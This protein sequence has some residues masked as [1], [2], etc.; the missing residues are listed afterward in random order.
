MS[1]PNGRER[2]AESGADGT[3]RAVEE[4]RPGGIGRL[5]ALFG[6]EPAPAIGRRHGA[7]V[8]YESGGRQ[9]SLELEP[10]RHVIGRAPGCD[11]VLERDPAVGALHAELVHGVDGWS[12]RDLDSKNGTFLDGEPVYH[13][14]L[15]NGDVVQVGRSRLTIG[16]DP[17]VRDPNTLGSAPTTRTQGHPGQI[18]GR[19]DVT[20]LDAHG[21]FPVSVDEQAS[22]DDGS[23][24]IVA[25]PG[26][27]AL[28]S[29]LHAAAESLLLADDHETFA[30][31][32]DVMR[33]HLRAEIA[34]VARLD[35]GTGRYEPVASLPRGVGGDRISQSACRL[36]ETERAAFHIEDASTDDRLQDAESI[37]E[38]S[39]LSVMCAPLYHQGAIHAVVYASTTQRMFDERLFQ[40]FCTLSRYSAVA[41]AGAALRRQARDDREVRERLSRYHAPAVVDRVLAA[42]GDGDMIVEERVV[43]VLFADLCGFTALA[44]D[45]SAKETTALLNGVFEKLTRVVFEMEGTLDKFTGDGLMVLYGAPLDQDDHAERAVETALRMQQCLDETSA[46]E[47]GLQLR[48]GI[49]TG[50]AVAADIGAPAR[51]D[52]TVVGDTVNVASRLESEVAGPGEVV[53]GPETEAAVR[54]LHAF[55]A[56]P[57]VRLRGRRE[58]IVPHRLVR[59]PAPGTG[60]GS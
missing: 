13:R 40:L 32:L 60:S 27:L 55:E 26:D 25:T 48:I 56:L 35:E 41:V 57:E 16:I 8:H 36:A 7:R 3:E 54:G 23:V 52:Y 53:V 15:R 47:P 46:G 22:R 31:V 18:V 14:A 49:N 43:T 5:K 11:I 2:D 59:R 20:Q 33:S 19:F 10:R 6:L 51:R 29:A 24:S 42:D 45:R 30:T 44:E 4:P 12:I 38:L 9:V 21:G 58:S 28:L 37:A 1:G 50:T 34:V 39:V 17:P